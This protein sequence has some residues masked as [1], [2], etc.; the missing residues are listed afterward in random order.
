MERRPVFGAV[1]VLAAEHHVASLGHATLTGE[2][3][4]EL[5]RF[6][7]D[8]VL[9]EVGVDPRGLE[10][11]SLGALRVVVEQV[12]RVEAADGRVMPFQRLPGSASCERVRHLLP[13]RAAAREP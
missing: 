13:E 7:G 8:P 1:D 4:Q 12:A 9:R 10:R 3:D 5:H 11:E 2:R 6:R